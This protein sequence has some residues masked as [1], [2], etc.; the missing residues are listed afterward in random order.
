M[1]TV[2][3]NED[4]SSYYQSKQREMARLEEARRII[5]EDAI[6]IH[7]Y[8]MSA[9]IELFPEV[10]GFGMS[11]HEEVVQELQKLKRNDLANELVGIYLAYA[12]SQDKK[13]NRKFRDMIRDLTK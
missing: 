13:S 6:Y 4:R 12:G 10:K 8:G 7:Y 9:F 2:I 11:W 1:K 5:S 3:F